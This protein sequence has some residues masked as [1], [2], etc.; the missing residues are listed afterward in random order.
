L[1]HPLEVAKPISLILLP[2]SCSRI[3]EPSIMFAWKNSV[4]MCV[5]VCLSLSLSLCLL[6]YS[7]TIEEFLVL[8]MKFSC[9]LY[10][11]W[12]QVKLCVERVRRG[13]VVSGPEVVSVVTLL[14]T[15]HSVR[16][17]VN[18]TVQEHPDRQLLMQP[19]LEMVRESSSSSC[20]SYK[21]IQKSFSQQFQSLVFGE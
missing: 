14:Q 18:A 13:A 6:E 4:C 17:S 7:W 15:S 21:N 19:L 5:C 20:S 9:K 11:G 1:H 8:L 2:S 3:Y 16:R 10:E 12:W